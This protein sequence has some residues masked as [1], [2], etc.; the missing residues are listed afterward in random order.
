[1]KKKHRNITIHGV[2]YGY[3]VNYS[4]GRLRLYKDGKFITELPIRTRQLSNMHWEDER[5]PSVISRTIEE[6]VTSENKLFALVR[7]VNGSYEIIHDDRSKIYN[8]NKYSSIVC[9]NTLEQ[10]K[11][12]QK[13]LTEP[14]K[15]CNGVVGTNYIGNTAKIL[16]ETNI[17]FACWFWS[18][19]LEEN[20]K[21]QFIIDGNIYTVLANN[22]NEYTK[23]FSGRKFKIQKLETGEIIE[24]DNLWHRGK[25]IKPFRINNPDNAKFI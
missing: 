9:A 1:M 25:M 22:K 15:I 11:E 6:Y 10:L 8:F 4:I 5:W 20:K 24:T 14:C 3:V 23:G 16:T 7:H 17:C 2:E 19:V 13:I 18:M 12:T 21:T